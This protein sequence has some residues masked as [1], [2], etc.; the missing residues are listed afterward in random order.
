VIPAYNAERFLAEA[1]ESVF[2]QTAPVAEVIVVD[3]GSTDATPEIASAYPAVRLLRRPHAGVS[4]ARNAGVSESS[5]DFIAFLDAD[6]IWLPERLERQ[7]ELAAGDPA[8]GVIMARQT[9]RFEGTPPAWFR[10]PTDGRSEA[11]YVPSNWLMRRATWERVGPFKAGMTHSE[12]TDWLSRASDLGVRV[13]TVEEVLVIHRIH[14]RNA[15]GLAA[16]VKVGIFEALRASVQRKR[17]L[18]ERA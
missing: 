14:D 10:G 18:D 7:M 9:Y 15:S 5:G 8:A 12:D 17:V 3:D 13:A 2:A 1:L 11:G 6:D 16:E 4:E